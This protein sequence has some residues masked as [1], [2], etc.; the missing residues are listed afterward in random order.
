VFRALLALLVQQ[1]RQDQ[2][3]LLVPPD[4]QVLRGLRANK[5]HKVLL[6][7]QA[8]PVRLGRRVRLE[9]LARLGPQVLL[10]RQVLRVL[11]EPKDPQALKVFK[12]HPV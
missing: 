6:E 12:D 10:A 9:P 7:S 11:R 1:V 3:V 2:P 8:L 5:V 4:L